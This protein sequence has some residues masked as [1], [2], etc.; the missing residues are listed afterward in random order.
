MRASVFVLLRPDAHAYH[1]DEILSACALAF[2]LSNPSF[3]QCASL[4][5][6]QLRL[7]SSI[8]AKTLPTK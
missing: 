7:P 4:N 6:S 2:G 1:C 3:L 5:P 8:D